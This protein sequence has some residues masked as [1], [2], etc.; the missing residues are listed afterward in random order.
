MTAQKD[1]E[2]NRE[3]DV[4]INTTTNMGDENMHSISESGNRITSS[5]SKWYKL[6]LEAGVEENGIRPVPP[7]GRTETQLSNLFTVFFT[8]LLCILPL[9]TGALGTVVYGLGLRDVSLIIIFFNIVTCLPPAFISLGGYKTGMRQMIQARYSFGLY[10]GVIPLLLNAGTVTGFSLIGSI[11]SGQAIA[12]VNEEANISVNVGI[13]IVCIL[14]FLLAFMGYRALHLWQRWQWLPNLVAIVIAV[15][16]GGKHLVDQADHDPATVKTVIG[17]GSLMAGYF[18]TF[19]GTVS[20]FTVYHNPKEA[21]RKVF[22]CVYLGFLIP[23]T[24]LLILGAAIGGAIPNVESWQTAWDGYGIGGVLAEMLRPAGGFGKFVLVV[25]AVS[26]VGNMVLGYYSV[27]LCLQMLVPIFTRIPRFLFII[28][29]LA[30]MIPMSIYAAA[31]WEESLT[32]FLSVIGYWAGC[33]DAVIIEEIVVF[34]NKDYSSFDSKIWNQGRRLPT[35]LA[36]IGAS[37]ISLGLVVPSM[38]TPWFTGPIGRQI[39]DIGFESA[40]IVTGIAYYPLRSLEIK[41]MGHV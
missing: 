34:R 39:G 2:A 20:D 16:C 31:Q 15:G 33:F 30:I 27:A 12:S 8:C 3:H 26:I 10:L 19:G 22:T 1:L 36:A 24:P 9:P 5:L 38:D 7:E 29:T 35:G 18:M 14:S 11:V 41:L 37:I 23:S 6:L 32:N 28:A 40:F 21:K 4:A 13:G 17:Y 25:L